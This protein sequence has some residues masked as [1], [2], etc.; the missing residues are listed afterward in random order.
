MRGHMIHTIQIP[1]STQPQALEI[2][3]ITITPQDMLVWKL[4][5][6]RASSFVS[7]QYAI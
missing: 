1:E 6:Y 2:T 7:P 5:K 4:K 3:Y